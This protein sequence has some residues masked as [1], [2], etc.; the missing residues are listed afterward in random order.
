MRIS[1]N[2]EALSE[3]E[4]A[5]RWYRE[6]GG[7]VPARAFA[8]ELRRVVELAAGQPGIGA[9]GQRGTTK[10]YFKR[11]PYTL[12]FRIQDSSIRVIAIAHQSRRPAYWAERR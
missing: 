2:A 6:N 4:E 5:T 1:F 8:Q 9:P 10:L 12:I 7:A 3:V 11:F